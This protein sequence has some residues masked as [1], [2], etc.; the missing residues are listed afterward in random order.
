METGKEN[1]KLVISKQKYA[2]SKQ[3]QLVLLL[4]KMKKQK[5]SDTFIKGKTQLSKGETGVGPR[6]CWQKWLQS[7]DRRIGFDA[8][9]G[10]LKLRLVVLTV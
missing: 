8:G 6:Q 3:M 10:H 4:F 7:T 9:Q 2:W 5:T 1:A